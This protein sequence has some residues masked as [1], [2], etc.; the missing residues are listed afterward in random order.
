MIW[1]VFLD[2]AP[3]MLLGLFL[4][5]WLKVLLR[6]EMTSALLGRPGLRSALV[7]ALIGIP[8]PICSCGVIPVAA[9]L[10]NE[11]ASKSS[12]LS[13]LVSTP[14]TGVDS[15]LAT[16]A[17][18]GPL[19]AIYADERSGN[20]SQ[21]RPA[22]QSCQH[23]FWFFARNFVGKP[24]RR[25]LRGHDHPAGECVPIPCVA[26]PTRYGAATTGCPKQSGSSIRSG[27]GPDDSGVSNG[28]CA[29]DY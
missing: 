16:Y 15:I 5:G 19:F 1:T 23:L 21:F 2:T 7:A 6:T 17:L 27:T 28:L 26:R 12:V 13:F 8:M 14:T 20:T 24:L 11:G 9:S 22:L 3:F 4:A 29:I 18:L 10:K 25:A